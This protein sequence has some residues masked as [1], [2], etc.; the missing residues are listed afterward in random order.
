[1]YVT[2]VAF[3][4]AVIVRLWLQPFPAKTWTLHFVQIIRVKP[5]PGL[6]QLTR[7]YSELNTKSD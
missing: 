6:V 7:F 3:N 1:M 5:F 2:S 4:R